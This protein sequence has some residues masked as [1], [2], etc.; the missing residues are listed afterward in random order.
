MDIE[1]LKYYLLN[2]DHKKI[3]EEWESVAYFDN[4][5]PTVNELLK[6]LDIKN[7]NI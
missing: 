7:K 2:T 6:Q 1:K 4:V 5:G 3:L